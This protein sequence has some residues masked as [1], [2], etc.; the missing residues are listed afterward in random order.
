MLPY[1]HKSYDEFHTGHDYLN[2]LIKNLI[3][4]YNLFTLCSSQGTKVIQI[5]TFLLLC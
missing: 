1:G 5:T 3:Y 4:N 2:V